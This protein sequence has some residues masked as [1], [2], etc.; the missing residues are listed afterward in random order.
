M[1]GGLGE[2]DRVRVKTPVTMK[3][4]TGRIYSSNPATKSF[5]V[6]VDPGQDIGFS[7]V[8]VNRGQ[9]GDSIRKA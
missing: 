5:V 7:R 9:K 4:V 1:Q 6:N 8:V 2:G 3:S